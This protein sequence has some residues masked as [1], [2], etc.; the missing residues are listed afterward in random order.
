[1]KETIQSG[2][3]RLSEQLD[4]MSSQLKNLQQDYAKLANLLADFQQ[5]HD[6]FDR[7][8]SQI[9]ESPGR[10]GGGFLPLVSINMGLKLVRVGQSL[11]LGLEQTRFGGGDDLLLDIASRFARAA[12]LVSQ[13][14]NAIQLAFGLHTSSDGTELVLSFGMTS[15][16]TLTG[17]ALDAWV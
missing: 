12:S 6:R 7:M 5:I 13:R 1:L 17:T 11:F 8:F 14:N 9:L 10:R 3:S 2:F 16:G 15:R 4:S